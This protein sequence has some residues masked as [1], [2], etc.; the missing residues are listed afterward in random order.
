[1]LVEGSLP[2]SISRAADVSINTADEF[3]ADARETSVAFHD[4]SLRNVASKRVQCNEIWSFVHAKQKNVAISKA[5]P[6][7]AGDCGIWTALDADPKLMNA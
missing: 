2:W 5:A 3:L 6:E 7:G 4:E 1:M